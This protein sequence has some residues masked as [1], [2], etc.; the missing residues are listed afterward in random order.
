MSIH[1]SFLGY[2]AGSP[3]HGR[4]WYVYAPASPSTKAVVNVILDPQRCQSVRYCCGTAHYTGLTKNTTTPLISIHVRSYA[5]P[6]RVSTNKQVFPARRLR[7]TSSEC[8]SDLTVQNSQL[9][10]VTAAHRCSR[11]WNC[12]FGRHPHDGLPHDIIA[13]E[14]YRHQTVRPLELSVNMTAVSY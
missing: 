5:S 8:V 13:P 9:T 2:G 6:S 3:Y 10:S 14:P 7:K 4:T 11:F 1:I 12:R